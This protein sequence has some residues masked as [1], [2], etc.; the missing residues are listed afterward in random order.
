[1]ATARTP[2]CEDELFFGEGARGAE[3]DTPTWQRLPRCTEGH[4]SVEKVPS[5]CFSAEWLRVPT[6]GTLPL[7]GPAERSAITVD[8]SPVPFA[9]LPTARLVISWMPLCHPCLGTH[10][11]CRGGRGMRYILTYFRLVLCCVLWGECCF[12]LA[13]LGWR[14]DG[15]TLCLG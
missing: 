3:I 9:A 1:M 2:G 6:D 4:A 8:T 5:F 7:V 10:Q 11:P 13:D 15:G 12:E 14:S